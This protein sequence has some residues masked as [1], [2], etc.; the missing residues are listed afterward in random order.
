MKYEV[1][2]ERVISLAVI[3]DG[4][5]ETEAEEIALSM[6]EDGHVDWKNPDSW[7]TDVIDIRAADE[8]D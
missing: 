8:D 7:F 2:I 6:S 1:T 3:V 5:D 4:E